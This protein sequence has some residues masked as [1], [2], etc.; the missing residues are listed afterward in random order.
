MD[1]YKRYLGIFI[2]VVVI[3]LLIF[4]SYSLIT[5]KFQQ[6]EEFESNIEK[7]QARLN[8][9]KKEKKTVE[10]KIKKMQDSLATLQKKLYAP[11]EMD[12]GDETLFFTLY[13]DVLEIIR[14]NAVK[15][16]SIDTEYNPKD[17]PFVVSGGGN[18]F[19]SEVRFE[20]IGN[21]VNLG[22]AIEDLYQYPYYIKICEISVKP[23]AKD[24]RVLLA[25]LTLR[26]YSYTDPID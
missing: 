4:G 15:I 7:S 9:K 1:R 20:L 16:K 12:L 21:Y 18:Y 11:V 19:V 5:P 24:K 8:S 17:D 14:S 22:K 23:H 10:D 6:I 25:N 13:N 26:L 3:G 2:F